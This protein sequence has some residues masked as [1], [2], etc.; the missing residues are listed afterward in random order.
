M[1]TTGY[2]ID[3]KLW[4]DGHVDGEY[5][6]RDTLVVRATQT[7]DGWNVRYWFPD[8]RSSEALARSPCGT[9]MPT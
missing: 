5:V 1:A 4:F 8:E 6:F 7:D 2:T 9:E 3:D